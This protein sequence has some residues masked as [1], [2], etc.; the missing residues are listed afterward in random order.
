L[1]PADFA[2]HIDHTLLRPTGTT[3]DVSRLC[4]E[5]RDYAMAA[6]C[7]FPSHVSLA[8]EILRNTRVKV[9]TVIAFPF[10]ATYIEVKAAEM[11]T[12][13]SMGANE[14]D[15]VINISLLKSG[16]DAAVEAEMQYL[17]GVAR[18]LGV[19]TKFIMETG[20][21]SNDE[22]VRVCTIANRVR[23]NFMKTST[24]Y[25]AS[26]ATVEDVALMRATL[27]PEIQIKAAG[28]IRSFSD[29]MALLQAGASR[30]GTSSGVA[31]V[32]EFRKL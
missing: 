31:I 25:G 24:G 15:I 19:A 16:A 14:A 32:E 9:A 4:T 28:G 23:P 5:A 22:K 26:G 18:G 12:A 13:A 11:R 3:T 2:R 6:V 29:A 8:R 7:V 21:L 10:G 17:T 20:S 27:L 30:I 1:T